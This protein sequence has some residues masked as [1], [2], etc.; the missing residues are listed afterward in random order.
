MNILILKSHSNVSFSLFIYF[1]VTLGV[2]GRGLSLVVSR[3]FFVSA[4]EYFLI[5]RFFISGGQPIEA[6]ASVLLLNI[7]D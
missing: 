2:A 7:Q 4:L 1:W 3:L 6:L 5:S